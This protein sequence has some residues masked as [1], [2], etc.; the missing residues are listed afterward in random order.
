MFVHYNLRL[1]LKQA[2]KEQNLEEYNGPINF[3]EIF[4]DKGDEEDP[5]YEWVKEARELVLDELSGQPNS[6]IASQMEVNV[7]KFMQTQQQNQPQGQQ[8]AAVVSGLVD[9]EDVSVANT[10]S[11]DSGDYNGQGHGG[12]DEGGHDEDE[13]EDS[14]SDNDGGDGAGGGGMSQSQRPLIPFTR[15]A[16]FEHATQDTNHGVRALP[17]GG[18]NSTYEKRGS[19]R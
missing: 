12:G 16:T 11:V 5:L 8:N 13:D 19:N 15:E 17:R 10:S 9:D 7:D 2:E 18:S 6:H 1:R 4:C 14:D 3:L